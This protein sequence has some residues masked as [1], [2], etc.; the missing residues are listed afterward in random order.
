M[1]NRQGRKYLYGDAADWF[2]MLY[3]LSQLDLR[4]IMLVYECYDFLY[5][6]MS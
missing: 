6:F 4:K 3:S 2:I 1:P 5:E